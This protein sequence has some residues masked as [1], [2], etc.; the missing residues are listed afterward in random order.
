MTEPV[1]IHEYSYLSICK[2]F[3]LTGTTGTYP[4]NVLGV[5]WEGFLLNLDIFLF[6]FRLF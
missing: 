6:V 4:K 2:L 1:R 5:W 3:F